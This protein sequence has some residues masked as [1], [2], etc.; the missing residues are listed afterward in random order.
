LKLA[1]EYPAIIG[2]GETVAL[3]NKDLTINW[4]CAPRIDSSPFFASLLDP[5]RGGF[6]RFLTDFSPSSFR[7][8]YLEKTNILE[9]KAEEKGRE[10]TVVDFMPW[11]KRCLIRKI[12]FTNNSSSSFSPSFFIETKSL[13]SKHIPN[14][15]QELTPFL[16]AVLG[17]DGVICIG[18]DPKSIEFEPFLDREISLPLLFPGQ[19]LEFDLIIGYGND[20][21]QATMAWKE[22][23]DCRLEDTEAFWR[24][25]L[26]RANLELRDN[27][28]K[29]LQKY[30]ERSLLVLKLL[31][32]EPTGAIVAAATASIPA[33]PYG[34]ENWDYRYI[35]LR[36]GYYNCLAYDEA[37]FFKEARRFYNFICFLQEEDG[38]WPQPLYTVEGRHPQEKIITDLKGPLGEEPIRFGNLAAMQLQL[39]NVGNVIHG[40]WHHYFLSGDIDFLAWLWP[41]IKLA[42]FWIENNWHRYEQGIWEIRE[43]MDHWVHGKAMCSV[44]LSAAAQ[45]AFTLGY[46]KLG[47]RF[48]RKA[49]KIRHHVLAHGYSTTRR[50]FLRHYGKDA[51]LDAS[52]LVLPL[53]NLISPTDPRVLNT[54]EQ[55][56]KPLASG[57][58]NLG[59]AICR[60]EG[61]TSAFYLTTLW[62]ARYYLKIGNLGRARELI[63]L[64]LDSATELGLMAEHFN[65]LLG[66]QYGNFPQAFSHSELIL[67]ISALGWAQ[68]KVEQGKEL[69]M[70]FIY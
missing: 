60:Y 27:E 35:W 50:A 17:K 9:T 29:K 59:G 36:D 10:L 64:C 47:K 23:F 53:Y 28:D 7:Q 43:R 2:N 30:Y 25:W 22:G 55:I 62:L 1:I 61:A 37:G 38:S 5:I 11:G 18:I 32:Y 34:W 24:N 52:V 46:R 40:I 65:P 48:D 26:E 14:Q 16:K 66:E 70:A 58:L 33:T 67:A 63:D 56:E 15:D 20:L 13:K 6:L 19:K 3:I 44:A 54:V 68:K 49:E 51:V 39:D 69:D 31:T 4:F 12:C 57:G 42:A 45:I 41:H 21:H 8:R